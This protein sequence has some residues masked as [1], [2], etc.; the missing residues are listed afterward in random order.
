MGRYKNES[1][2]GC[3]GVMLVL[4]SLFAIVLVISFVSSISD[5]ISKNPRML[6]I[7]IGLAA[8]FLTYVILKFIHKQK[9]KRY[10]EQAFT[11][12]HNNDADSLNTILQKVG[13]TRAK[14]YELS[15]Y[16]FIEK[17]FSEN[18]ANIQTSEIFNRY[19]K[20]VP[21]DH[22]VKENERFFLNI[23]QKSYFK[24]SFTSFQANH[25]LNMC[26]FLD[27]SPELKKEVKTEVEILTKIFA[28]RMNG[29]T[30]IEADNSVIDGANCYYQ[31]SIEVF[32]DR[33]KDGILYYEKDKRGKIYL[34]DNG[35]DIVA[36]GHKKIKTRDIVNFE[37]VSDVLRISI[38]NRQK[39]LGF[40]SR[41][42][43]LILEILKY[44]KKDN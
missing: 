14:I 42:Q 5:A 36:D 25:L 2:A 7:P 34:S 20:Y 11:A 44:L 30:P 13:I 26:G 23:L 9:T 12:I 16:S 22:I 35:I 8:L 32:R 39:P 4:I 43:K 17:F 18:D 29:L 10:T 37:I 1:S 40:Y 28:I 21:K 33:I 38:A 24:K 6:S 27:I 19:K 31:G 3:F 41:E 15:Y